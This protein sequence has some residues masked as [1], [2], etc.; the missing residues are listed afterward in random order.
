MKRAIAL[1]AAVLAASALAPAPAPNPPV[2]ALRVGVFTGNGSAA[3]CVEDAL[4]SLRIDPDVEAKTVSG[5]EIALGALD[6]LDVLVLPGGGGARQMGDLGEVGAGRVRAFVREEGKG[7][8]GLC[9]GAYMLSD[10]PDYL[11]LHLCPVQA[12]DR[13]HDERGHGMIAFSLTQAGGEFFP[14]LEASGPGLI[15]YYEGPLLIPASDPP[16]Y[17]VLAAMDTDVHLENDAPAGVMPGKP[18]FLSAESGK[19]RVFLSAGHPESTP[20]LRWIVPRAA[21]W[22]ARRPPI[23]YTAAVVRP[24]TMAGPVLF[25]GPLRKEESALLQKL[26][27]GD[28]AERCTAVW[29]LAQIRSWEAPRWI[30]GL[31]RDRD[32]SVRL[33]AARALVELERTSALADVEAAA[34][35]ESSPVLR[36]DLSACERRLRAMAPSSAERCGAGGK[37]EIAVTFDDLPVV[38]AGAEGAEAELALTRKLVGAVLGAGVPATGFVIGKNAQTQERRDLLDVWL[39]AGLELGNHTQHH[40]SL[41]KVGLEAYEKDVLEGDATLR[42][43]L[44]PSGAAPRYFR[45]PFLQTG[46]DA[47]IKRDFTEFLAKLGYAAA[48]VTVDNSDWVFA[49][50]YAKALEAG[51]ED[52]A[53]RIREAYLPYLESKVDYYERESM[54]LLGYEVKQVLLLHASALN[55]DTFSET[56]AMLKR[57][58][59]AF[60]GLDEALRDPAYALPDAYTG[61][62]GISWLHRWAFALRGKAGILP[63]EPLCPDW[64]MKAA[65]VD[66][67]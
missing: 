23:P 55:A 33:C 11:C 52:S 6:G 25:D 29:R 49:R 37:R 17:T 65:G 32:P 44:S 57:R 28:A 38:N 64:V 27:Y 59:Y 48:P 53:R 19:G 36:F 24:G 58:G 50:A 7:V 43:L 26:L 46:Q 60:I 14:E 13:E 35:T 47:A 41:H 34:S 21:R 12:V 42:A 5:A 39:G 10:T 56:G 18:L 16:R 22:A 1:A 15:Y 31:L 66:S 20:G 45:H 2:E 54:A 30:K 3:A 40:A 67:E 61:G 9:A 63:G 8:V 62:A 51:D 4:Q